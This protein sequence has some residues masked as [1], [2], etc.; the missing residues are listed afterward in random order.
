MKAFP[1]PLIPGV[2]DPDAAEG[3]VMVLELVVGLAMVPNSSDRI[4]VTAA[5]ATMLA[6]ATAFAVTV[7]A[8]AADPAARTAAVAARAMRNFIWTPL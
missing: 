3:T 2:T 7:A 4:E 8:D 5:G 6:L 1:V